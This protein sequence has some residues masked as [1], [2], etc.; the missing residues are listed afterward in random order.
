MPATKV[1]SVR[2]IFH[3][4]NMR[5]AVEADIATHHVGW[6]RKGAK[7]MSFLSCLFAAIGTSCHQQ[8]NACVPVLLHQVKHVF[9]AGQEMSPPKKCILHG[10]LSVEYVRPHHTTARRDACQGGIHGN[11]PTHGMGRAFFTTSMA[12]HL[13]RKSSQETVGEKFFKF[14]DTNFYTSHVVSWR[15][16]IKITFKTEAFLR[17]TPLALCYRKHTPQ[18]RD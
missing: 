2:H 9:H 10:V 1:G 12:Y 17:A 13:N 14:F 18:T 15:A 6:Y 7:S 3:R 11:T 8:T 5:H 16:I 4:R